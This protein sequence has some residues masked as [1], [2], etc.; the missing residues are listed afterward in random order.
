MNRDQLLQAVMARDSRLDGTFVYGVSSTHIYCRPSCPSK[1]PRPENITFFDTVEAATTA[2]FRACLRCRP[3]EFAARLSEGGVALNNREFEAAAGV[4]PRDL[5]EN[6]RMQRFKREV[7]NG[8]GVLTAGLEAGFGSTRA[9][10]E[11]APALLGMTPATYGKGGA[12][13]DIRFATTPCDL[14]YLLVTRTAKGVC[15]VALGDDPQSLE[16]ALR[17][18]FFAAQI[19][20]DNQNLASEIEEVLLH[21]Q[22]NSPSI[23]LPLDVRATA[24]QWQVWKELTNLQRGETVS[25]GEL[26]ARLGMPNAMRAVASACGKNPV[27]LVHPCHRVV[28]KKGELAGYRWGIERK[29]R[30]LET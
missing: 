30:L 7:R 11:R 18:E 15:S 2:R 9:L 6:E 28:G 26:A 13:A 20:R 25:Y 16:K 22:G 14:G 19:E 1:R 12:G 27:A 23:V 21:L 4:S 24:F 17:S 5:A 29:K 3:D 10:Y 8:S